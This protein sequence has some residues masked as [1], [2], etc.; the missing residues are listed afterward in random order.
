[1]TDF[2]GAPI[3]DVVKLT[4]F[5]LSNIAVTTP[6]H[7]D[8]ILKDESLIYRIL[9]LLDNKNDSIKLEANWVMV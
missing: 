7:A 1:M 6:N 3:P 2:L 8:I 9:V 4:L 5:G